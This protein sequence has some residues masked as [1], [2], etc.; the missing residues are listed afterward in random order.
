MS[1]TTRVPQTRTMSGDEL[2][3][4]DAWRT[5][6]STGTLTLLRDAFLRLRY[7]D[8]FSH[9]RALALQMALTAIPGMIALVGL[10]QTAHDAQ[11]G[12]AVQLTIERVTPAASRSAVHDA[13]QGAGEGGGVALWLGLAAAL[14]SLTVAMG[15]I[16]RGANRIYGLQR[17]RPFPAKYGGAFARAILA[18]IPI[19]AGLALSVFGK[20]FGYALA[21]V[22]KWSPEQR[23]AWEIA[24][25]PVGLLLALVSAG[26]LFRKAPR[27]RQPSATWLVFGAAV[28]LV[29]WMAATA[30]LAW[31]TSGTQ[32]FSATY[33]P[34]TV[35]LAFL[36]WANVSA[37][38]LFYGIAFA[39]QLESRRAGVRSPVTAD[40]GE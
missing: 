34:L 12:Q 22:Y 4:D 37:V 8:G 29:L 27:R 24:R 17:D 11:W 18:G 20:S 31:Y 38:A 28:A 1:T 33:G 7:G 19:A 16:E 21:E 25:W 36:I 2:S 5:L 6:R 39:A 35:V 9:A 3:A 14:V 23:H 10:A 26:V 15:Q 40:P 32:T 13:L 30:L